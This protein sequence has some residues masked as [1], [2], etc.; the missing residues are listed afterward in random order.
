[1]RY[2]HVST[3]FCTIAFKVAPNSCDYRILYEFDLNRGC[4]YLH[5]VGH[6]RQIYKRPNWFLRIP[7]SVAHNSCFPG[8]LINE[9]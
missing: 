3:I 6:R 7:R 4:I 2:A 1:M 9:S 8:F 5:Y